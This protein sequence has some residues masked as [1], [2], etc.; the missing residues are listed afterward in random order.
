MPNLIDTYRSGYDLGQ[1]HGRSRQRRRA[2]WELRLTRGML[3]LPL[4]N[5]GSYIDGY[6]TG[7]SDALRLQEAFRC[8]ERPANQ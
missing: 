1:T 4:V 5:V 6:H 2:A 3:W 7:Y 8:L